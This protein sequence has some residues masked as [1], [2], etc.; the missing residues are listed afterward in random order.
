MTLQE[1]LL[2]SQA[3]A[4]SAM[5]GLIWFVQVVHY[6]LFA[7]IG[8]DAS[9]A[10]ADEH[11]ARTGRVVMPFMLVE[12]LSAAALAWAPPPGVPRSVAHGGLAIVAMLW[13][14]TAFVQ[15][16]LHGRLSREGHAPGTVAALV[17]SNCLRTVLWSLR[18]AVAV[19]MLRVAG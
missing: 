3:V 11:Q 16:P 17:R 7:R 6:P 18:A 5:C 9:K 19:W 2:A 12:G 10:F 14:L 4:S 13:L 1:L 8:G 15:M